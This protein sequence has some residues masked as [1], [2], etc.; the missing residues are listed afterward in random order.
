MEP[1]IRTV[2]KPDWRSLF[3]MLRERFVSTN[4]SE[5]TALG[6]CVDVAM[7]A[8]VWANIILFVYVF[9]V[10]SLSERAALAQRLGIDDL[11]R[12]MA[13]G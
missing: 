1:H 2:T 7:F 10:L 5:Q 4:W 11:L 3:N 13:G 9:F 6:K 12:A 8:V